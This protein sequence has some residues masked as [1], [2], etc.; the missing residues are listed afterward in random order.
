LPAAL[1]WIAT[2]LRVDHSVAIRAY[3]DQI[4]KLRVLF[5]VSDAKAF[6]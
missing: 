1:Q 4:L 3:E 6:V 2:V 5:S